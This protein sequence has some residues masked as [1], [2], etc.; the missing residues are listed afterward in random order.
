MQRGEGMANLNNIWW[1]GIGVF[2][3][4]KYGGLE[5]TKHF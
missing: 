1:I 4:I 5:E 3:L 2:S